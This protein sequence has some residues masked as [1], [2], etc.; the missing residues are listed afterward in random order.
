MASTDATAVKVI[1]RRLSMGA[2]GSGIRRA[3]L[4]VVCG[5]PVHREAILMPSPRERD[6]G[7][8]PSAPGTTLRQSLQVAWWGRLPVTEPER[9]R[10]AGWR[11]HESDRSHGGA[12]P[13]S[14]GGGA[15]DVAARRGR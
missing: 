7:L 9:R 14:A 8:T 12:G 10:H 13:Q 11:R 2:A 4:G 15:T 6:E 1:E 3:P 5:D